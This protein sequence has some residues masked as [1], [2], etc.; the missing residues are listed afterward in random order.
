MYFKSLEIHTKL[1]A[2]IPLGNR[3]RIVEGKTNLFYLI[4]NWII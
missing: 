2:V 3:I 4:Y 1:L